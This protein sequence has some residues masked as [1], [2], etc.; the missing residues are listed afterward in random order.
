VRHVVYVPNHELSSLDPA[1]R[2]AA[3]GLAGIPESRVRELV[4]RHLALV[5]WHGTDAAEASRAG[6]EARRHGVAAHLSTRPTGSA[7][8]RLGTLGVG[9][10]VGLAA[11][12]VLFPPSWMALIVATPIVVAFAL[13]AERVVGP[14]LAW[15]DALNAIAVAERE[16]AST[17]PEVA[18]FRE[19]VAALRRRL[20]LTDV[21]I[22]AAADVRDGLR[23]VEERAEALVALI[24]TADQA[25]G[26][27]DL[28]GMRV[29]LAGL[30]RSTDP[31]T[32][33]DRDVLSRV[34]AD[35]DEVVARRDRALADL[36]AVERGL[37]E[38]DA[39]LARLGV[40]APPGPSETIDR[41]TRAARHA[42]SA[43]D[44]DG[45]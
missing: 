11:L 35:L 15:S 17:H 22:A 5:L 10:L 25:I 7:A 14:R 16:G 6:A 28:Q 34:V 23:E 41:L 29:R 30:A 27:S 37:D 18:H 36:A 2:S 13:L 21:P 24:R 3:A 4:D 31:T 43:R 32:A 8:L 20:A 42:E 9:L 45:G 12:S 1:A 26:R 19:R 40:P 39:I 44:D 38:V 33:A